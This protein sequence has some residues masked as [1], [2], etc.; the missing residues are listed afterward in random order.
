VVQSCLVLW[1]CCVVLT[2]LCCSYVCVGIVVAFGCVIVWNVL[3]SVVFSVVFGV[4]MVGMCL[5][6]YVDGP[7]RGGGRVRG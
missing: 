3:G 1:L 4:G 5:V 2:R 6:W 7:V